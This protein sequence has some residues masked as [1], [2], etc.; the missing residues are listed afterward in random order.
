MSSIIY[1]YKFS[2]TFIAALKQ[3]IDI[4]RYDTT[5]VFK[6]AWSVWVAEKNTLIGRETRRLV[7]IGYEG[8]IGDKMYK[9]ARY[10]YKN[11]SVEEVKAKKRRKYIRLNAPILALMDEHLQENH[12]KPALS[13][14]Q[15]IEENTQCIENIHKDLLTKGLTKDDIDLKI[16]KTFKNRYFRFVT[17]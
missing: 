8:E 17:K 12:Q 16:R 10:Y 11:K 2:A 15:F 9:S 1:R 13:Y 6:E 5:D 7:D 3:F 14:T 4:H